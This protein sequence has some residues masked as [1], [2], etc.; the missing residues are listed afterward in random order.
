MSASHRIHTHW[1]GVEQV[2]AGWSE[3]G[4]RL[5]GVKIRLDFWSSKIRR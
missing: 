4:V 1:E 2:E 3:R 5:I